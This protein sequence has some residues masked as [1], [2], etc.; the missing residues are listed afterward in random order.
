MLLTVLLLKLPIFIL[1][2][3]SPQATSLEFATIS[4]LI[5]LTFPGGAFVVPILKNVVLMRISV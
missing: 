3:T 1:A 4:Y 2:G 5:F